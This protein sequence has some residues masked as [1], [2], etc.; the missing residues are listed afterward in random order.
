MSL[1]GSATSV[2]LKM[3]HYMY[4]IYVTAK[5]GLSGEEKFK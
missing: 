4:V 5:L 2:T 1:R 3:C